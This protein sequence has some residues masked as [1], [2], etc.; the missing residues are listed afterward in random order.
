MSAQWVVGEGRNFDI[1]QHLRPSMLFQ[2][3]H[4]LSPHRK[5]GAFLVFRKVGVG[6]FDIPCSE[7][8]FLEFPSKAIPA[9]SS[10]PCT[11]PQEVISIAGRVFLFLCF[12]FIWA[13][14]VISILFNCRV[15]CLEYMPLGPTF[16]CV[17]CNHST[18]NK[19][20]LRGFLSAVAI[21]GAL[22][23]AIPAITF[24]LNSQVPP[25]ARISEFFSYTFSASTFSSSLPITYT[26]S[27]GPGW[28]SLDSSTRTLS[29]I[30]S[31]EDAG[32]G[33][34]TGV[35]IDIMAS[36]SSGSVTQNATLVISKNPAPEVNVPLSVQFQSSTAFS[37][38]STLLYHPSTPFTINFQPDTFS[39]SDLIYYAVTVENTPLP[40]WIAF[41]ES[42]L[43]FTG[44]TPDYLSL[45]QPPQTFGIQLIASDV[46]GFSG[47]AISFNVEVGVH[48]LAFKDTTLM[49]YATAGDAINFDGLAANLE[50]DEHLANGADIVSIS[51]QT[52]SWLIF[53]NSTFVLSGTVPTDATPYNITVEATDIYGDAAV[54]IVYI[55]IPTSLF[56]EEMGTLNATIGTAFDYDLSANL[57]NKSDIA[58]TAQFAPAE[59]WLFFD[60]QTFVLSGQIPATTGPL[61][62]AI[63]LVATSKSSTESSS[64]TF[65]LAL[66]STRQLPSSSSSVSRTSS[67]QSTSHTGDSATS[68]A[69]SRKPLSRKIILAIVMPTVALLICML[70]ALF[71]YFWRRREA[72]EQFEGF[73]KSEISGPLEAVSSVL[74]IVWPTYVESPQPLE[75]DMTGF[76]GEASLI[77]AQT[78][79]KKGK[80]QDIRRSQTLSVISG[81]LQSQ[82]QESDVTQKRARSYSESAVSK[83]ES[84]WLSTKDGALP[85]AGSSRTNSSNT[86]RLTRNY[87]N[88]SRKGH[89]RCSAKVYPATQL[90]PL[91][92][93]SSS[94]P[95]EE[96]IL[97]LRD[98][99][100]SFAP[101]ENFS[102]VKNANVQLTDE[103]SITSNRLSRT[104][105][106]RRQS[107]FMPMLG[108]TPSGLG[109]GGTRDSISSLSGNSG[110]RRIVGHGQNWTIGQGLTRNSRTWR[111]IGSS[112]MEELNR[113]STI[114]AL[115]DYGDLKPEDVV[116]LSTIRQVTKSPS[117]P[118]SACVS[119]ASQYSRRSRPVSRRLDSSPF[120]GGS[121][122]RK[123][124]KS[125][126][127]S[128]ASYADSPTVP[129]DAAMAENL[130][131]V[132]QGE[133]QENAEI[134]RDSFGISYGL[135]R[136]GTRQLKSY[137]QSHFSRSGTRSSMKSTESKDSRFESASESMMSLH[138]FHAQQEPQNQDDG[139]EYEDYLPDDYLEGGGS[140]E[141]QHSVPDSQRS[142]QAKNLAQGNVAAAQAMTN[143]NFVPKAKISG[144]AANSPM[145]DIGPN[146]RMVPGASRRPIS[147][148]AEANKRG[149]KA[150]IERG[151]L[152]Y[153]AYI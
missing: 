138:Q 125:V 18:L 113:R 16:Y 34:V 101:I 1:P 35:I 110:N 6:G 131:I 31:I 63:T 149:S 153:A 133:G 66:I 17:S 102:V 86:Q 107:R 72:K 42:S 28:L 144:S 19:M 148:D 50:I 132:P 145:V 114:S 15:A 82:L 64:Q 84:S 68:P 51:A 33:E 57:R 93:I 4:I 10:P 26:L 13:S 111:T 94:Q 124:Q 53:D 100:F 76:G 2:T 143:P 71:C 126:K 69:L 12:D 46:Q 38:P 120:F 108:R 45:I 103:P 88:Y 135:A 36:D 89:T 85:T 122:S 146:M 104:K 137:V 140:W 60:P 109:H 152:D 96:S 141:T 81:P 117:I 123:S 67:S 55:D 74:E 106:T 118:L 39:G 56:T 99:N 41:D 30:P 127:E 119:A 95:M 59:P 136:E 112:E 44:Q 32:T 75:L 83:A 73:S 40:S 9:I 52:P 87:S 54:A 80:K 25:V 97:N 49:I 78:S 3:F 77:S 24:P 7:P 29:G 23:I 139:D 48:L 91:P 121:A 5:F 43:T 11:A 128:R 37:A 98:S 92:D 62:I 129:Q 142:A 22:V 21:Y 147:V 134:P 27:D 47:A 130:E 70:L 116:R 115:S 79:P 150:K 65:Q 151:E 105:S 61:T 90:L 58:L 20:T 8:F 14:T